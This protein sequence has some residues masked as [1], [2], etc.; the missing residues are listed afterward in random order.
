[1]SDTVQVLL[2]YGYVVLFAFVLAEQIGLPIPAVPV[3]LGI[4][5]LAGAGRMSPALALGVA[6]AAS[7]P[8]DVV[9]YELGRRR[10]GRVLGLL[11]R[12]SL[13]PDSC[14]RRTENLFMRHGRRAL[15][16][17]K[18]IPG[19]STIA[20]P[21]A[22]MVGVARREFILL[23][24][25]GALVWAAAWIGLGYVFSGALELAAS[26]AAGLG[27]YALVV[28]G[29]ALA[30]YVVIKFVQRRR[31]FRSLR[32]AQ[33]TA[34]ELKRRLDSRDGD[35]III[36]TRS[37]LDVNAAPYTIPGA[38]WIAAEEIGR[39]HHEVPRDREIVLYCS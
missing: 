21:L 30:T 28:L 33:I 6:L 19:L 20:P 14:V 1:M 10:G 35:L 2:Q 8:P 29:A 9:W 16:I 27:N 12:I 17:A 15:L 38:M 36:D 18:F 34:D 39:R 7:L 22:G 5:A 25:V 4:G 32:M 11:C 26:R 3:L 37:A 23:D 31:L 13:E 24:G